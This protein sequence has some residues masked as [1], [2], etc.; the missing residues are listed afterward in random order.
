MHR[1]NPSNKPPQLLG[2]SASA[3]V[4]AYTFDRWALTARAIES[5][6]RQSRFLC[7]ILLIID[8]NDRL[9]DTFADYYSSRPG[10][11]VVQVMKNE[12][13]P[14]LSGA[15]NTGISKAK[16]DFIVFLDDDA[17]A[18]DDCIAALL[19][20]YRAD[21]TVQATGGAATMCTTAPVPKWWPPEYNW[22]VGCTYVGL[23]LTS[24]E[25]RNVMGCN[26]SV[27]T[28]TARTLGGF[29]E[30]MGRVGELPVGCEET[31]LCIRIA[32]QMPNAK[33][34]YEP[35]AIAEHFVPARRL[36]ARYFLSRCFYE[37]R[38]K[39][40]LSERVGPTASLKS[41]QEYIRVTLRRAVVRNI[42][43][44]FLKRELSP[45][46]RTA[47]IAFG[48]LA[49]SVGYLSVLVHRVPAELPAIAVN[50]DL[51]QM[52]TLLENTSPVNGT[53]KIDR[54]TTL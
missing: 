20:P 47:A 40:L 13:T 16:G 12:R 22:V 26:M 25:V 23:P 38:S 9:H 52:A 41:E 19:S 32:Q 6:L 8:N 17:L 43:Q 33:I 14:G 44:V 31:D 49:A 28:Q 27:R 15:R 29:A 53:T 36:T 24:S 39:A 1:K 46:A 48:V 3:I 21:P 18:E 54:V 10:S 7:E 30:T 34:I 37:G 11:L 45:L 42:M 35:K 5:L 51:S 4:C 50:S 2:R